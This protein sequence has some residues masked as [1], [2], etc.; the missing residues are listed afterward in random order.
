MAA[1]GQ[2]EIRRQR[3]TRTAG[4]PQFYNGLGY[5]YASLNYRLVPEHAARW[6]GRRYSRCASLFAGKNSADLGFN[7]DNIVLIGHS[8]GAHLAALISADTRYLDNAGVPLA[9]LKATI[10]LDGAGY[11]VPRRMRKT[12][13]PK[14]INK[15]YEDAFTKDIETQQR[16]SPISHV[17]A[18]NGASWLILHVATRADAKAQSEALGGALKQN[19][20]DAH[21]I[22]VPDST[23]MTV[24]RDAGV[25]GS[26]VGGQIAD[27]LRKI[28]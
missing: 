28:L 9:A 4:K 15:M 6:A 11:D 1:V 22:S 21:V 2:S 7:P 25:S 24:N 12:L 18:P 10:L 3:F 16:L 26:F 14:M 8:A 5:A 27:F 13:Q 20:S 17:A 19:G 23:H